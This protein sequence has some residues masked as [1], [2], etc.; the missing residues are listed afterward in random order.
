GRGRRCKSCGLEDDLRV[1]QIGHL[2]AVAVGRGSGS[3]S[4]VVL[5]ELLGHAVVSAFWVFTA[6]SSSASTARR[7]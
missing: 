4:L 6:S 1:D 5:V 3:V 2:S 7:G